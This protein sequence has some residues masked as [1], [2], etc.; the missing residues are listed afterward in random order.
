M[1]WVTTFSAL[2]AGAVLLVATTATWL[3]WSGREGATFRAVPLALKISSVVAGMGIV[4]VEAL[5]IVDA[6]N[7]R[8]SVT[9]RFMP[10]WPALGYTVGDSNRGVIRLEYGEFSLA[11]LTTS[12]LI[13]VA[14]LW[15]VV[16]HVSL[17][18][19]VLVILFVVWRIAHS[20]ETGSFRGT[21]TSATLFRSGLVVIGFGVLWQGAAQTLQIVIARMTPLK[22]ELAPMWPAELMTAFGHVKWPFTDIE[23]WP[24]ILG[25]VLVVAA[26]ALRKTERDEAELEGLI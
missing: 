20:L 1:W 26:T 16:Q 25:V 8:E 19:L 2:T 17:I 3:G 21:L 6:L 14:Q 23:I 10:I 7:G 4:I 12:H 18:A 9:V 11:Q 22:W 15:S 5:A 13:G 24:I